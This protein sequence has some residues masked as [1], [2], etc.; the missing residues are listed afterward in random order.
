MRRRAFVAA[1]ALVPLSQALGC[2]ATTVAPTTTPASAPEPAH[3]EEQ[4]LEEAHSDYNHVIVTEQGS[5]RRMYFETDGRW[6]LQSTYELDR[7]DAL[8]HEVFQTMVSSM[9]VQPQVRRMC[10]IGVGGGQLSNYLFRH[11]PGLELDVVDICPEVV[12]LACTYFGVPKSDPRYRLHVADGRV[13][14]ESLAPQSVDLLVLDAFRGHSIPR[15]L[16]TREFFEACAKR[17]APGGVQVA[18]MHRRTPRYPA[19][20]ATLASVFAH[21]YRF[22]SNDDVQTSIVSTNTDAALTPAQLQANASTLQPNFDFDLSGLARRCVVNEQGWD[23]NA[24]A[25]DD[26]ESQQLQEAAERHN[27]S[28]APTCDDDG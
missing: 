1:C 4:I 27:R 25:H 12:R 22:A 17:L 8:H 23:P 13:F 15:H 2:R 11:V 3:D 18:N 16:R 20:R 9:L 21:N 10:M 7:P 6:L 24:I 5:L 28:C 19:D 26:F 14:I